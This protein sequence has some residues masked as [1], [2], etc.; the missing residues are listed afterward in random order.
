MFRLTMPKPASCPGYAHEQAQKSVGLFG[1][2][3][4][5]SSLLAASVV[6]TG[7]AFFWFSWKFRAFAIVKPLSQFG[8]IVPWTILLQSMLAMTLFLLV[9]D[10]GR[11]KATAF[12]TIANLFAGATF[13]A[14]GVFLA[15]GLLGHPIANLD[16]WWFLSSITH[17]KDAFPG[18]PSPQTSITACFLAV[19]SLVRHPSSSRRILA[20][21]L[22]AAG[23]L[24]LP[25]LAG[26]GYVFYVTPLFA[27]KPFFLGMSLPAL[28]LFVVL[29]LG[30]FSLSPTQGVVG[31]V[32]SEGLSGKTARH[33]LSFLLPLP[34]VLG[35]MLSYVTHEGLLSEQVAAALSVL[36]VIVLLM[37]LTLHLAGLIRRHEDAQTLVATERSRMLAILRA[38]L[39]STTDAIIVAGDNLEIVDFNAKYLHMWKIPPEVMKARLPSEVREFASR[40]FADPQRYISRIMEI[41]ATDLESFDLL[42]TKDGRFFVIPKS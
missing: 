14:A 32:I 42:G 18:R 28:F 33:F 24:F 10:T 3:R 2:F 36:I 19:A 13:L 37:I 12:K 4:R 9:S 31:I 1:R 40:N 35:W 34:V 38:T 7:A 5:N 22:I 11:A 25:F 23:G 16:R 27:G 41:V 6:L 30:L 17:Y 29:A 26:L 15:E 20:S 39:E 21:Q 8:S